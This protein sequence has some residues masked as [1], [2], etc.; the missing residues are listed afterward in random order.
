LIQIYRRELTYPEN[1]VEGEDDI[2]EAAG[3]F[4]PV[5]S[6]GGDNFLD[7]VHAETDIM[8]IKNKFILPKIWLR[9]EIVRS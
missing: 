9:K 7:T 8:K 1:N 3:N 5:P 2:F 4:T 6:S